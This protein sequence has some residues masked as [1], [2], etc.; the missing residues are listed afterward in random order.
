MSVVDAKVL[1]WAPKNYNIPLKELKMIKMH[2]WDKKDVKNFMQK[3]FDQNTPIQI[4]FQ[5]NVPRK[6]DV[7]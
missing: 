5:N 2:V 6:I 4:T 1:L 7:S 3:T